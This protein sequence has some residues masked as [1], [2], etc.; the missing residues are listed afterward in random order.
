MTASG[1]LDQA[2]DRL[3][4]T[5]PEFGGD[6]DGNHGLANHGPMA[7]EVLVRRG[8]GDRVEPWLDR[9]VTRLIDLPAAREEITERN[10]VRAIGAGRR[11][12]GD[13]TRYFTRQFAERPWPDVLTQWWPTLL[14]GVTA[15]ATH[16][17]IR[18]GHAVRALGEGSSDI[19]RSELAHGLAFWAARSTPI[20][21]ATGPRGTLGP[22]E[23]LAGVPHLVD[24]SGL[25]AHRLGRLSAL[26]GWPEAQAAL[27]PAADPDDVPRLLDELIHASTVRYLHHAHGSP[28]LLVH[29]ATAPNAIRNTLPALPRELWAPSLTAIW[30]ATAAIVAAYEP[31]DPA[32]RSELPALPRVDDVVAELIDR[33]VDSGDEHVIKFTDTAV[34][35]FEAT[36]DPDVLAAAVRAR[37]LIEP[38]I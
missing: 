36:G 17:A 6:Q 15:G 38:E 8:H 1:A 10:L 35:V 12:L 21:A 19:A 29:T 23:A 5:G 32:P 26:S 33:A 11:R 27:Q 25:I 18:V 20:P 28:I 9:Y 16:G 37:D 7:A 13:W 22:A 2:Y 31:N 4:H 34:D 3:H 24:Q 30:S 14:P